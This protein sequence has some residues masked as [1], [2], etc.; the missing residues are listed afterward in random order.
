MNFTDAEEREV[1]AKAAAAGVSIAELLRICVFRLSVVGRLTD[2]ER[3]AIRELMYQ[4]KNLNA[5]VKAC[6]ANAWPSTKRKAETCLDGILATLGKLKTSNSS[7][8]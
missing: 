5:Q 3:E 2:F 8:L 6:Q 4:G 1:K 7:L